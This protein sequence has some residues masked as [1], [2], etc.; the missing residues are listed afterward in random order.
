MEPYASVGDYCSSTEAIRGNT[1]D[2]WLPEAA[3]NTNAGEVTSYPA[4]LSYS[5]AESPS[6]S[7]ERQPRDV[8]GFVT[9]HKTTTAW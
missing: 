5:P 1:K 9:L 6:A 7:A 3:S 4:H 8:K 2:A